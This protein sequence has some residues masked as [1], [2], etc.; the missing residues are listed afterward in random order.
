[1]LRSF[2]AWGTAAAFRRRLRRAFPLVVGLG[3]TA[4]VLYEHFALVRSQEAIARDVQTRLRAAL[5]GARTGSGVVVV[6]INDLEYDTLFGGRSPLDAVVLQ[7]LLTAIASGRPRLIGV[8]LDTS[9][10]SFRAL[11]APGG[12]APVVWARA[13]ETLCVCRARDP[14]CKAPV[15][16]RSKS[17]S[18]T[19]YRHCDDGEAG[20]LVALDFLGGQNRGAAGMAAL[21]NDQDAV[22]RRYERWIATADGAMSSF[23][24]TIA[25]LADPALQRVPRARSAG[26]FYIHYQPLRADARFTAE[27]ILSFARNPGYDVLRGRVV[28]LGGTYSSGRD[29]YPTPLGELPGV[30]VHAHAVETEL[31]RDGVRPLS[32]FW[33][34]SVLV[35]SSAGL[36]LLFQRHPF[37]RAFRRAV[38]VWI[39]V[40]ATA[41]SWI[42]SGSPLALW[43]YLVPILAI[44]LMHQMRE[45][46]LDRQS[47]QLTRILPFGPAEGGAQGDDRAEY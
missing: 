39:P 33:L 11:R 32:G 15:L 13:G 2:A 44:I 23:P 4:A 3:L 6:E 8:D 24:W 26:E 12:T 47:D 40:G 28:V 19:L 27:E 17:G 37:D 42:A 5:F 30:E 29:R 41:G 45:A 9:H 1:V 35:L 34:S 21:L 14:L 25:R 38:L 36:L 16:A 10:P 43:P 7:R 20:E 18:T 22:I 46:F 31:R